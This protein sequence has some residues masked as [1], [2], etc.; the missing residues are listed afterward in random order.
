GYNDKVRNSRFD[1]LHYKISITDQLLKPNRWDNYLVNYFGEY[2]RTKYQFMILKTGKTNWESAIFPQD[3]NFLIQ[4][5]K[6]DWIEYVNNN[7]PMLDENGS[8]ITFP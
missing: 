2:S 6:L 5:V 8:E 3:L 7:G 4:T 1:R